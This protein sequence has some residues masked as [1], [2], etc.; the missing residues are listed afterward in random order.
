MN[1]RMAMRGVLTAERMGGWA[2]AFRW[3][4]LCL[5]ARRIKAEIRYTLAG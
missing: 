5:W 1:D 2:A 4:R 3:V